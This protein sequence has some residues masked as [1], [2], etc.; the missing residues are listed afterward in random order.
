MRVKYSFFLYDMME[1]IEAIFSLIFIIFIFILLSPML[2]WD[3]VK[4]RSKNKK[5]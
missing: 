4:E 3:A 5:K 2:I 1:T